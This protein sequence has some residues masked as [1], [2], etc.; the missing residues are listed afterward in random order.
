MR[1]DSHSPLLHPQHQPIYSHKTRSRLPLPLSLS[2][3]PSPPG[4]YSCTFCKA[5]KPAGESILDIK[6]DLIID[7]TVHEFARAT[8]DSLTQ[9]LERGRVAKQFYYT[10]RASEAFERGDVA[11]VKSVPRG[12]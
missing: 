10:H 6:L 3:S 1:S 11:L 8:C 5:P 4:R 2:S 7:Q 9:R 12:W